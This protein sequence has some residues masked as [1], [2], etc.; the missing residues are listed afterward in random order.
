MMTKTENGQYDHIPFRTR[1]D[2]ISAINDAEDRVSVEI[3]AV[4]NREEKSALVQF[5]NSIP[6]PY[7][8]VIVRPLNP[9]EERVPD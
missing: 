5:L 9:P 4:R 2:A 3:G 6:R 8:I 7:G 1:E